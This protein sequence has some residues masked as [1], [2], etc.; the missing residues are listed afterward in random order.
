M[1]KIRSQKNHNLVDWDFDIQ[2]LLLRREANDNVRKFRLPESGHLTNSD[3][4]LALE[5]PVHWPYST[6]KSEFSRQWQ[7]LAVVG[8]HLRVDKRRPG[9]GRS[10]LYAHT[11]WPQGHP[12]TTHDLYL[13]LSC[14]C[15]CICLLICSFVSVACILTHWQ[16]TTCLIG[17]PGLVN[18]CEMKW[19]CHSLLLILITDNIC[20]CFIQLIWSLRLILLPSLIGP[21]RLVDL[22]DLLLQL[23]TSESVIQ[24]SSLKVFVWQHKICLCHIHRIAMDLRVRGLGLICLR[25]LGRLVDWSHVLLTLVISVSV[26]FATAR[27]RPDNTLVSCPLQPQLVH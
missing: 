1:Y 11:H 22:S 17:L 19:I 18:L 15:L 2:W 3:L 20:L 5:P 6:I 26:M 12:L 21:E 14:V 23:V 27:L 13:S 10:L 8:G 4:G 24:T 25:G 7:V 16:H 9:A